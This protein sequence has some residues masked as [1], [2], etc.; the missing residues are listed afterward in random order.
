MLKFKNYTDWAAE[1]A[2]ISTD[3][4]YQTAVVRIEMPAPADY[5]ADTATWTLTPST[6]L[7]EGQARIIG[8]RSGITTGQ[9]RANMET[10]TRVTLQIPR[11]G[12]DRVV[13]GVKVTILEAPLNPALV[14]IRLSIVSDLQG[15]TSA[16][17]T[18]QCA[19][20]GDAATVA[21]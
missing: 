1:I 8:E 7:Y 5:N 17:R 14:G 13:K 4:E 6:L 12:T 3:P 10:E 16:A 19:A 21:V 2:E 15:A 20:P 9:D 18:F 11:H